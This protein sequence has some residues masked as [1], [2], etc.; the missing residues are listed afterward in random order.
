MSSSLHIKFRFYQFCRILNERIF[1]IWFTKHCDSKKSNSYIAMLEWRHNNHYQISLI[2]S[3]YEL[4]KSKAV[5]SVFHGD[6]S[7][8][9][10]KR[11]YGEKNYKS[12]VCMATH[13]EINDYWFLAT[14]DSHV[15]K[16]VIKPMKPTIEISWQ[17]IENFKNSTDYHLTGN[18]KL[19]MQSKILPQNLRSIPLTVAIV[20]L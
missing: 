19:W 8:D 10:V 6:L 11:Y 3:Q 14:N 16:K 1:Y 4:W 18:S 15:F 9:W 12:N 13:P 2:I 5:K 7:M 20:S 17:D